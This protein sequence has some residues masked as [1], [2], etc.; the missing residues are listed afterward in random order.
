MNEPNAPFDD[1]DARAMRRVALGDREAF[2]RVVE[3]HGDAVYRFLMRLGV[4][5]PDAEDLAQDVFFRIF[6]H[7]A[8]YTPTARFTTYLYRV[9]RNASIDYFRRRGRRGVTESLDRPD[10]EG[11]G[12]TP[13]D[14]LAAPAPAPSPMERDEEIRRRRALLREA[15]D[16]LPSR[17]RAV[18]ALAAP[19]DMPYADIAA[20]LDIPV[21]TVKSRMHAAV[22]RLRAHLRRRGLHG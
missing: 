10:G 20:V 7:A 1:E 9:A 8:D 19:G 18:F 12:T 15:V 21:G 11:E 3:R 22:H 5:A 17:E 16:S 13:L 4:A 14:R 6:A 2:G